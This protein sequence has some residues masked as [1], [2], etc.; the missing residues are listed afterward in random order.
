M[1]RRTRF[2]H[3]DLDLV[4]REAVFDD[5]AEALPP[6]LSQGS[7]PGELEEAPEPTSFLIHKLE[8]SRQVK[9]NRMEYFDGAVLSALA[10]ISSVAVED[11]ADDE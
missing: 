5:P 6:V 7:R 8:Q 11:E 4:L 3:L 1:L 9:S 10:W 2:L